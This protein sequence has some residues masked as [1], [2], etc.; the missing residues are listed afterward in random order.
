MLLLNVHNITFRHKPSF[1]LALKPY[2]MDIRNR[3]D[4]SYFYHYTVDSNITITHESDLI[5]PSML[6]AEYYKPCLKLACSKANIWLQG[7]KF[8][9]RLFSG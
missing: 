5:Q 8:W 2:A 7:T 4:A 9:P 1:D 3:I 6:E